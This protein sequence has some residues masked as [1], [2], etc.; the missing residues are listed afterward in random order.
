MKK[1]I[2][3]L[4][5]LGLASLAFTAPANSY[6]VPRT[7][8]SVCNEYQTTYCIESVTVTRPGGTPIQLEYVA[9]GKSLASELVT[10]VIPLEQPTASSSTTYGARWT[11]KDW[12][13][14]GLENYGYQGMVVRIQPANEFSNHITIDVIPVIQN[15]DN[16]IAKALLEGSSNSQANLDPDTRVSIKI[17]SGEIKVGALVGAALGM[18][19]QTTYSDLNDTSDSEIIFNASPVRV[20]LASRT[21][22]CIGETGIASSLVYRIFGFIAIQNDEEGFGIDGISGDMSVA[23]NGLCKLSTPVWDEAGLALTWQVAAPHFAPDGVTPNKGFYRAVIPVAD[24][25]L[26]WGLQNPKLAVTALEITITEEEQGTVTA[27]KNVSVRNNHIIVDVTNFGYSSPVM[28]IKL[29]KGIKTINCVKTAS[30]K[31]LKNI[32]VSSKTPSCPT[33]YKRK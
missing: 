3:F 32:K 26:L 25:A 2:L 19:I 17:R 16:T 10:E 11:Y 24:A 21:S 6:V 7:A 9:S 28:K 30:R 8:W 22:D 15:P 20:P 29:K 27:S 13:A 31:G 4:T 1:I 18:S 14:A 23:S 5:S 33:G 12:A